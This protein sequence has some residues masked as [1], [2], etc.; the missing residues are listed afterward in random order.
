MSEDK[1]KKIIIARACI[2]GG[3]DLNPGAA[4][5]LPAEDALHLISTGKALTASAA[6]IK[7]IKDRTAPAEKSE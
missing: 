1:N 2:A 5:T 7:L 6:N 3:Q 4:I